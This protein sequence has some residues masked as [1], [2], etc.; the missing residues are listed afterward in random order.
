MAAG[1]AGAGAMESDAS[2]MESDAS[3]KPLIGIM[4][5]GPEIGDFFA[6]LFGKGEMVGTLTDPFIGYIEGTI[7]EKPPE[8]RVVKI[9]FSDEEGDDYVGTLDI[10]FQNV[11]TF[12]L[13]SIE[14]SEGVRG[15]GYGKRIMAVLMDIAERIGIATIYLYSYWKAVSFYLHNDPPFEFVDSA[16]KDKYDTRYKELLATA[17]PE[18]NAR[19]Q[20]G[21]V[22]A[23]ETANGELHDD[24]VQMV[25]KLQGGGAKARKSRRRRTNRKRGTRRRRN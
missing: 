24:P 25:L 7:E 19:R 1:G 11:T 6:R 9:L 13:R 15:K 16:D 10:E 17:N 14:T 23:F 3:T 5:V 12:Y 21:N 8:G 2:A 4:A 20:A 22:F 18:V